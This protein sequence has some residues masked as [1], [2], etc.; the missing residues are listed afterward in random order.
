MCSS[1]FGGGHRAAGTQRDPRT[2]LGLLGA[3]IFLI[4]ITPLGIWTLPNPVFAAGLV[5]LLRREYPNF[6]RPGRSSRVPTT[7]SSQL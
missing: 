1:I 4:L 5:P 6:L 3:I 2:R 7:P